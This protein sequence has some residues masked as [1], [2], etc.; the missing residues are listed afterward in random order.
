MLLAH[1]GRKGEARD[2]VVL[3]AEFLG[4]QCCLDKKLQVTGKILVYVDG[5]YKLETPYFNTF[6]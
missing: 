3:L 5:M 4:V 6:V 2:R 1:E